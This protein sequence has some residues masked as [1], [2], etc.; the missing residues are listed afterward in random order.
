MMIRSGA[1]SPVSKQWIQHEAVRSNP[2][3]QE[4]VELPDHHAVY[5]IEVLPSGG[6]TLIW[7]LGLKVVE[8]SALR[9]RKRPSPRSE[10]DIWSRTIE[11][12]L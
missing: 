6:M 2:G 3:L 11:T 8:R 5:G 4:A 9:L 10:R 1:S 12:S 7:F